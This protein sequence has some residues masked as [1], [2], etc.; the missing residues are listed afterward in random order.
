MDLT[1]EEHERRARMVDP[2][3]WKPPFSYEKGLRRVAALDRVRNLMLQK[4]K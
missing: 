3:A 1:R 4:Q 2:E